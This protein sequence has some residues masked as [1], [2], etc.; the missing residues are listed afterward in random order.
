VTTEKYVLLEN[1]EAGPERVFLLWKSRQQ[2]EACY[3]W[4]KIATD[5]NKK[6]KEE[7]EGEGQKRQP[8]QEEK[9]L[10]QNRA[11][12]LA[13]APSFLKERVGA[14]KPL[15]V[16]SFST[17]EDLR[18]RR[19]WGM[20]REEEEE[21]KR[22]AVLRFVLRDEKSGKEG[23]NTAVAGKGEGEG[24]GEGGIEGEGGMSF[25][26]F[27]DFMDLFSPRWDPSR[28]AGEQQTRKTIGEKARRNECVDR[29]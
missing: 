28:E 11:E 12:Y 25:D 15:P 23:E 6:E 24:K 29:G 18:R 10:E 16:I 7:V 20:R 21:E 13:K 26:V 8:Q 9:T 19:P 14:G 17:L 4:T 27:L 3:V 22:R 5:K 2:M 1:A